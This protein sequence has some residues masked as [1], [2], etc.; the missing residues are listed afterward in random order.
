MKNIVLIVLTG[1]VGLFMFTTGYFAIENDVSKPKVT[2]VKISPNS[3]QKRVENFFE[4]RTKAKPL[5]NQVYWKSKQG[6]STEEDVFYAFGVKTAKEALTLKKRLISEGYHRV[7]RTCSELDDKNH[8]WSLGYCVDI[9]AK[10]NEE[11]N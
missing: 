5:Y 6:E 3:S 1:L 10:I 4:Y 8:T 9:P 11:V 2:F 7:I